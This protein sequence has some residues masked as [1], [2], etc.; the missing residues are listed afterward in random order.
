MQFK[1]GAIQLAA[2][3]DLLFVIVFLQFTELQISAN[4][5]GKIDNNKIEE[6]EDQLG[7]EKDSI[8]NVIAQ[9]DE[10]Q[11]KINGMEV[12]LKEIRELLKKTEDKVD[13]L[14]K[15]DGENAKKNDQLKKDNDKLKEDEKRTK[16]R[17]EKAEKETKDAY[18]AVKKFISSIDPKVLE[19]VI[20]QDEKQDREKIMKALGDLAGQKASQVALELKKATEIRNRIDVFEVHIFDDDQIRV[21]RSDAPPKTFTATKSSE[22]SNTFELYVKSGNQPKNMVL[23]LFTTGDCKYSVMEEVK[24]GIDEAII[25]LKA[26]NT[27]A[28][29]QCTTPSFLSIPPD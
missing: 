22:F 11:A 12:T 2:L 3:V 14:E 19:E 16:E 21:R 29:I 9:R 18:E 8:K 23:I 27:G 15:K 28:N 5:K 6:L 17:K 10:G 20:K 13:T 25:K 4:Q 26:L 1:R 24:K 7:K